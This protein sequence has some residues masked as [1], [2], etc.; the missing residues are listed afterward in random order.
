[1]QPRVPHLQGSPAMSTRP[2][3]AA[4]R[5]RAARVGI[6]AAALALGLTA[7]PGLAPRAQ[8]AVVEPGDLQIQEISGGGGNAGAVFQNHFVELVNTSEDDLSVDG[9]TL[10]YASPSGTFNNALTLEGIVGAG[11]VFLIQ[12][13]AGE[14]NGEPW[15]EADI[16][17]CLNSSGSGGVLAMS[18]AGGA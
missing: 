6:A 10:Q 18:D 4:V 16:N 15:P 13:A 11:E 1:P 17:R 5:P 12:L 14:G 9:W 8:A 7:L 2:T 3:G